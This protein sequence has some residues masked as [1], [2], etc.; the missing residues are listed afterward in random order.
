MF[1]QTM[2]NFN[3]FY[4]LNDF[5]IKDRTAGTSGILGTSVTTGRII[6]DNRDIRGKKRANR[7]DDNGQ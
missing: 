5:N 6:R 7:D 3:V 1:N 2:S 4:T